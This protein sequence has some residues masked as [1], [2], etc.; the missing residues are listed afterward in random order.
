MDLRF[1]CCSK[2]VVVKT[3]YGVRATCNTHRRVW[4]KIAGEEHWEEEKYVGF[5]V[6]GA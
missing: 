4:T 2:A 6:D 1:L 5:G 3:A